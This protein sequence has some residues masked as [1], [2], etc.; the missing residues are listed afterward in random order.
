MRRD[1]NSRAGA[2]IHQD[3]SLRQFLHDLVAI[4][5]VDH[6]RASALVGIT[7]TSHHESGFIGQCDQPLS[8]AL[9]LGPNVFDTCLGDDLVTLD[10]R[11]HRWDARCAVLKTKRTVGVLDRTILESEWS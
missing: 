2:I 11:E 7:R 9:G 4:L 6:N 8:L 5:D 3:V 10:A 1:P